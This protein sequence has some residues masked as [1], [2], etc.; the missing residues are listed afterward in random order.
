M[1]D[2]CVTD[3]PVKNMFWGTKYLVIDPKTGA[4]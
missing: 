2:T 1:N 3:C 4:L